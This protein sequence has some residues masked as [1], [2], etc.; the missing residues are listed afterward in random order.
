[1]KIKIKCP[2]CGRQIYIEAPPVDGL[3]EFVVLHGGHAAKI[4]IDEH[5]FV[6]RAWPAPLLKAE[7]E[8]APRQLPEAY[9]VFVG[10]GRAVVVGPGGEKLAELP[11]GELGAAVTLAEKLA[12]S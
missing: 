4:Y 8:E 2:V 6:R 1:M 3:R 9:G 12:E 11:T 7:E 5:Y 10:R